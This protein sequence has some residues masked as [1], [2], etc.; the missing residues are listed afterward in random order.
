MEGGKLFSGKR[1]LHSQNVDWVL[2]AG[3]I[4]M[5][6]W[7]SVTMILPLIQMLSRAFYD[8]RDVYVGLANF[9]EYFSTPALAQSL[10]NSIF[11]SVV[12]T[13]SAVV[14]AFLFAYA[15]TRTTLPFNGFFKYVALL[16][17]FRH[18]LCRV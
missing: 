8:Q 5:L 4:F 10:F 15:V 9:Y 17:H 7:F 18:R 1:R 14:A 13:T 3:I 11:V 6:A 16:P 12:A 2:A